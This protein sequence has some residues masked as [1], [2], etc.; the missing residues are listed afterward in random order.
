M[1]APFWRSA[2]DYT[3]IVAASKHALKIPRGPNSNKH[4]SGKCLHSGDPLNVGT[5]SRICREVMRTREI[6]AAG[7]RLCAACSARSAPDWHKTRRTGRFARTLV[8]RRDLPPVPSL[9]RQSRKNGGRCSSMTTAHLAGQKLV[10][11]IGQC[12]ALTTS[13]NFTIFEGNSE[14]RRLIIGRAVTGLPVK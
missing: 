14:I 11:G 6:S 2:K 8:T 7:Q 1:A 13:D 4:A 10:S 5:Q 3:L 9:F 12:S